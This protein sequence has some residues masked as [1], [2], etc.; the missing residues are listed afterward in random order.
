MAAFAFRHPVDT[1]A[2]SFQQLPPVDTRSKK[3]SER[4][5]IQFVDMKVS[6]RVYT[7]PGYFN[8]QLF[9]CT[10]NNIANR[11]V[12]DKFF[13][14]IAQRY[15]VFSLRNNPYNERDVAS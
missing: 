6:N 12:I 7:F 8:A 11:D 13:W 1:R 14:G 3:S 10:A 4:G 5:Q 15:Y 2:L 9:Q